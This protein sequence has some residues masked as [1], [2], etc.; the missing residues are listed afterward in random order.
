MVTKESKKAQYEKQKAASRATSAANAL[1]GRDIGMPPAVVD[2]ARR[3]ACEKSFRLFCETYF[4]AAFPLAW[5]NDHLAMI[6]KIERVVLHGELFAMALPRGTGKTTLAQVGVAWASL[7]GVTEYVCLIAATAEHA[8]RLLATIK[9]WFETNVLLG[10]DFP[11]VCYPVR[12]L[13]GVANRQAGQL[14]EG[15]RTRIEWNQDRVVFPTIPGSTLSGVAISCCGMKA[16]DV[17]GQNF[18]RADGTIARPSLV[19]IDEPQT[20]ESAYSTEQT[21]KRMETLSGD[22]LGLAGPGN[23]VAAFLTCTKILEGDLACQVLD[24]EK[25]PDWQ[26]QCSK[27][28]ISWPTNMDAWEEYNRVRVDSMRQGHGMKLATEYYLQHRELLDEGAEVYWEARYKTGEASA[29]QHAM[30]LWLRPTDAGGGAAFMAEYQNEPEVDDDVEL[31]LTSAQVLAKYN[32]RKKLTVPSDC[33]K[34]TTFIDVHDELMFWLTVAW[35]PNFTGYI[36]DYGTY[37]DQNRSNFTLRNAPKGLLSM[38]VGKPKDEAIY[39]GVHATLKQVLS[40]QYMRDDGIV[41]RNDRVLIDKGYKP[42]VIDAA[43]RRIG[44]SV[45]WMSRGAGITSKKLPFS[46]HKRKVGQQIGDFW[47]I[48]SLRGSQRGT[49]RYV[50]VDTNHW[51]SFTHSQLMTAMGGDGCLSLYGNARTNHH[52]LAEHLANSQL[53]RK[54]EDKLSGRVVAEWEPAPGN[55]DNHWFDCLVGCAVAASMEGI[56]LTGDAVYGQVRK[57]KT[58]KLPPRKNR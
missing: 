48:P 17:R 30:N 18:A 5:S 34:L 29:I 12:R 53:W 54:V 19:L 35:E 47:M 33:T 15:E 49:L 6:D 3:A 38:H 52:L 4:A 42:K 51:K 21:R 11:E 26:G 10:E 44:S 14:C 41:L 56:S 57:R 45:V 50:L 7:T 9:T 24:N 25:C 43:V 13:D 36:I 20:R 46:E 55:T 28:L 40:A 39:A 58:V 16:N 32:G 27:M 37:P 22:V 23:S 1:A 2:P 8:K 31:R